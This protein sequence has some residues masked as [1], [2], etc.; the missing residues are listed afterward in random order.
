MEAFQDDAG[1]WLR[2]LNYYLGSEVHT[3]SKRMIEAYLDISE[4]IFVH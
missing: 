2:E 1:A 4:G 3:R